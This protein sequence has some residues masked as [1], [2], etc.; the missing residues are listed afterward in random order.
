MDLVIATSIA[1]LHEQKM[2]LGCLYHFIANNNFGHNPDV[3]PIN[4][5]MYLQIV[6]L[7]LSV[8]G[9]LLPWLVVKI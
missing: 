4:A 6:Q 2:G 9:Q 5:Q 7:I 1:D 3:I 8:Q